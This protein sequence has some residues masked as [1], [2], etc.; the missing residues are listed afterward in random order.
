MLFNA[1]PEACTKMLSF[2]YFDFED[3]WFISS[4]SMTYSLD[5]HWMWVKLR[6]FPV[7]W[8]L[9]DFKIQPES[10]GR[11]HRGS[12]GWK[13][14]KACGNRWKELKQDET[15]WTRIINTGDMKQSVP[16]CVR[17]PFATVCSRYLCNHTAIFDYHFVSMHL[18]CLQTVSCSFYTLFSSLKPWIHLS[19]NPSQPFYRHPICV[20]SC[21]PSLAL[22][23][24]RTKRHKSKDKESWGVRP[25]LSDP[26]FARVCLICIGL[27][28]HDLYIYDH[29]WSYII[30]IYF[31]IFFH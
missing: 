27:I 15:W 24:G 31:Y 11:L 25:D 2:K 10:L 22:A 16:H 3:L 4:N 20:H 30:I 26:V 14:V 23:L 12:S 17:Y 28:W 18:E 21:G 8:I 29:V 19:P 7:S 1:V 9:F 5:L 13:M 6:G